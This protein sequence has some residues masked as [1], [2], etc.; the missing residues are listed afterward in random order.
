MLLH[1]LR[2]PHPPPTSHKVNT[3][4]KVIPYTQQPG[5][6]NQRKSRKPSLKPTAKAPEKTTTFLLGAILALN[7]TN[8]CSWFQ[9]KPYDFFSVVFYR[10][11]VISSPIS[12][13]RPLLSK[14]AE[15][16]EPAPILEFFG[17]RLHQEKWQDLKPDGSTE[18]QLL[19]NGSS[20]CHWPSSRWEMDLQ[21]NLAELYILP[22]FFHEDEASCV[23]CCAVI[24]LQKL[25]EYWVMFHQPC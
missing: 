12:S 19:E 13:E 10:P 22:F 9:V 4:Q 24:L 3:S 14:A 7:F 1:P 18:V 20:H 25:G 5:R 11:G 8:F 2:P 15:M 16:A 21:W 17:C 6:C 23:R